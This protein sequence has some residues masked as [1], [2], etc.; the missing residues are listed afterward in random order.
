MPPQSNAI[1]C[2]CR[3]NEN[4]SKRLPLLLSYRD[5]LNLVLD[6]DSIS[7]TEIDSSFSKDS[8]SSEED[9]K[10]GTPRQ[11]LFRSD[12]INN[13]IWHLDELDR[14]KKSKRT[15]MMKSHRLYYA[16]ASIIIFFSFTIVQPIAYRVKQNR[17]WRRLL[18]EESP[19]L[20]QD[21]L[22]GAP[23]SEFTIILQGRRLDLIQQS[24]DSHRK[25]PSVREIQVDFNG[26]GNI[27]PTLLFHKV[28]EVVPIEA[29]STKGVFL[30]SE[31]VMLSCEEIERGKRFCYCSQLFPAKQYH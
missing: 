19:K 1:D 12:E 14:S 26:P 17:N 13:E 5:E 6:N 2:G 31:D 21:V 20:Q 4:T 8:L 7:S 9:K 23:G 28:R 10:I 11:R 29:I 27:P 3:K 16:F 24:L 18:Q 15:R 30:L 25:C 22:K